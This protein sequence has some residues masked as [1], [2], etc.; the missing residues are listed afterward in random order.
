MIKNAGFSDDR[1]Y[2][3]WL[4]RLWDE[5]ANNPL[6]VIGLNP[7]TADETDDDPTIRR[8]IRFARDWG[9]TSLLML[10]L[11]AYRSTDP[12]VLRRVQYPVGSL[13]DAYIGTLCK[14]R[15]VL[16][17]W[18][19]YGALHQRGEQVKGLISQLPN[20]QLVTLGFTA[21]GQPK[22]PL[23]IAASTLP[24]SWT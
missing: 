22:H 19:A 5:R 3:Y 21:A 2:R 11:F 18:G 15:R 1:V 24:Q 12:S 23:Y 13:N 4:L 14:D 17:A 9:H 20:T 8:C 7:S 6:V 10:N 16:A